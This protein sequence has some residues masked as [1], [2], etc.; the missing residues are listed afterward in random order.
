MNHNA[1]LYIFLNQ[2][3]T[4]LLKKS[5]A[6]LDKNRIVVVEIP[7]IPSTN[8]VEEHRKVKGP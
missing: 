6:D 1:S 2:N 4:P 3:T 5:E 7:A 8:E